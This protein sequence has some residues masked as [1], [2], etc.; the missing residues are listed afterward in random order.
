MVSGS[1]GGRSFT[2]LDQQTSSGGRKR[3]RRQRFLREELSPPPPPLPPDTAAVTQRR[4]SI[5]LRSYNHPLNS[6]PSLR[7]KTLHRGRR[8]KCSR[9]GFMLSHLFFHRQRGAMILLAVH[10]H[11]E[12]QITIG[13]HFSFQIVLGRFFQ[14]IC[15]ALAQCV[16]AVS[17]S[18]I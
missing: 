12:N 1:S 7:L 6:A 9:L 16:Q 11:H 17:V 2:V 15:S 14:M 18:D 13:D 10:I 4:Q 8:D 5:F 3:R